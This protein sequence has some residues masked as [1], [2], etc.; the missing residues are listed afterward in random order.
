MKRSRSVL[1]TILLGLGSMLAVQADQVKLAWDAPKTN[2]DGTPF[3]NLACYVVYCGRA[4]G[5]YDFGVDAGK[6]TQATVTGLEAGVTYYF[7]VE[8]QN[9]WNCTSELSSEITA[10]PSAST[11]QTDVDQDGMP[12]DWE[13]ANFGSITAFNGS[14]DDDLDGDGFTNLEEYIA[15]TSPKDANSGPFIE[16]TVV[17]RYLTYSFEALA[18]Y[19][20]A[21]TR[22]YALERAA[23]PTDAVW[24]AVPGYE[25][26]VGQNQIVSFQ[27]RSKKRYYYRLN[28]WL[29]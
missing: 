8:A 1:I 11:P 9:A 15:G 23:S 5:Q 17:R 26:I 18:A 14:A 28:I 4:P 25:A 6:A 16:T 21:G 10:T 13:L 19:P 29:Q 27:E 24:T 22:Y 3:T 20:G 7:A 2:I 12:D